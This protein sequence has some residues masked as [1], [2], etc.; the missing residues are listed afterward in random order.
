MTEAT[1]HA[2][3]RY[4]DKINKRVSKEKNLNEPMIIMCDALWTLTHQVS[5]AEGTRERKRVAF[6]Q[7]KRTVTCL[8]VR[9]NIY[10]FMDKNTLP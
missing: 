8:L 1:E 3:P 10:R 6:V 9:R 4:G 5:V 7:T 2:Q